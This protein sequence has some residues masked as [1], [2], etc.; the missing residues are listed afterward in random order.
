MANTERRDD[1]EPLSLKATAALA[2]VMTIAPIAAA[3][4]GYWAGAQL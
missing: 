3:A 2:C 4:Y 1:G